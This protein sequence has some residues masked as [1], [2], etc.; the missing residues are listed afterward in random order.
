MTAI[1]CANDSSGKQGTI[2]LGLKNVARDDAH[3][4]RNPNGNREGNGQAR[5]INRGHQQKVRE[6]EDRSAHHRIKDI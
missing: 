2:A 6:I 4:Q 3:D 5:H 1:D